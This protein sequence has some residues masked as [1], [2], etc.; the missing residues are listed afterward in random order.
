MRCTPGGCR[1]P[2]HAP[3]PGPARH[4]HRLDVPERREVSQGSLQC[5]GES[6]AI[7]GYAPRER[8]HEEAERVL[9][10]PESP[11]RDAL[12]NEP[13]DSLRVHSSHLARAIPGR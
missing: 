7:R 3:L 10:G 2:L 8:A 6:R 9:F 13:R 5:G 11:R 4:P 12:Q 1:R